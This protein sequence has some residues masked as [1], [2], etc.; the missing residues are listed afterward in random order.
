MIRESKII[1][2]IKKA[3]EGPTLDYKEDL[4]LTSDGDKAQFVKDVIA[5]ANSGELAH[6]IVG[7]EDGTGKPVGFKTPHTSEQINQILKDKCDPPI[8]VEYGEKDIL[9]YA[10]GIIEFKGENPP[11]IVSVPD[12][13]GGRLSSNPN[14]SFS[15]QR[16]TV[17]ARTYNMNQGAKRADLDKIYDR[18]KYISLQADIQLNHKVSIKHSNGFKEV[19][20]TFILENRGEVVAT[21]IYIW[22]QFKNVKEIV[23][24]QDDW[25]DISDVNENKPTIQLLYSLPVIRP[26]GM[27]CYGATVKVSKNVKQIE[28]RLIIG[29][30]NM[31]TKDGDYLI[32]L[33][34]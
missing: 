18:I 3:E 21:D 24:C 13:F 9:G 10:I 31:R 33:E 4:P 34:K 32:S 15:I 5:L 6:I 29:A 11:Y 27:K 16:G 1:Q 14:K 23:R 2:L 17:S 25:E 7:V 19:G 26:V 30:I 20:I 12:K 22:M 28:A 8:S